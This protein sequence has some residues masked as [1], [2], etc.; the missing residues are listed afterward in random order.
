MTSFIVPNRINGLDLCSIQDRIQK[1]DFNRVSQAGFVFVYVKASQYSRTKD[2]SFDSLVGRARVAGLRVGAYHFCAHDTDPLLQAQFF[3][4][5]SSA[6]GSKP[7]ELPP[8]LDWEF[9]TPAYY[10]SKKIA[11]H[12]HC[13]TWLE[14]FAKEVEKLWY[15]DNARHNIPRYPVVY[16]YPAYSGAHQPELGEASPLAR[17]HLNLASYPNGRSMELPPETHQTYHKVPKPWSRAILTQ[18]SGDAGMPVPGIVGACDR[19]LWNGST[20]EWY[21]F[22]GIERPVDIVE[23]KVLE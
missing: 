7:G 2:L 13:V 16:S 10:E 19:D 3:Y 8:M 20:G 5:A 15:P 21:D 11:H 12:K 6:L 23:G 18:Y 14:A 9:C 22:L 4:R 1:V 17:F